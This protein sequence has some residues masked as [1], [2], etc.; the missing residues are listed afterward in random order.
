MTWSSYQK[1]GPCQHL[2]LKVL[3][4]LLSQN[5]VAY[6][7]HSRESAL[8]E[9]R[10]RLLDHLNGHPAGCLHDVAII[11]GAEISLQSLQASLM[12]LGLFGITFK[13][14]EGPRQRLRR[15]RNTGGFAFTG[16][17]KSYPRP[18]LLAATHDLPCRPSGASISPSPHS[19]GRKRATRTP[20]REAAR[21]KI[22]RKGTLCLAR[23]TPLLHLLRNGLKPL[24]DLLH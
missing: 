11:S 21:R 22:E 3:S 17:P 10:R 18:A 9:V 16:K 23:P 14:P 19:A 4:G 6:I 2:Y 8:P 24:L 5:A 15:C 13:R 12:L 1:S 20:E 7:V